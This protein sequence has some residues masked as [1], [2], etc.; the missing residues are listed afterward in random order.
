VSVAVR[1]PAYQAL[2]DSLRAQITSGELRPGDRLP[3]EP[4]L[5]VTSGVSRSTVREA[6]RL[7]ASQNLIITTR[8]VTGGS[9]VA[10][11]S[12]DQLA[13]MLSTGV[14][15][16][17]SRGSLQQRDVLEVRSMIEVPAT[18][19]AALRRTDTQLEAIRAALPV[20]RVGPVEQLV[21]GHRAFHLSI[22][23]AA[24]NPLGE[25][26]VHPLYPPL[27]EGR[28]AGIIS[29]VFWHRVD[30]EHHEIVDAV[31]A[32]DAMAAQR[33]ASRHVAHLR[34]AFEHFAPSPEA[35]RVISAV[36]TA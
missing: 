19:Y 16:M 31:A 3:T 29:D 15:L 5:C 20:P 25:L 28:L 22:A 27:T 36:T 10:H 7:L 9:F 18:G 2:A 1:P 24:G 32:G 21:I 13:T 11:P 14:A 35:G 30:T 4:Q 34:E 8:G 12:V 17:L 33:A 6:L 23:R 26:L